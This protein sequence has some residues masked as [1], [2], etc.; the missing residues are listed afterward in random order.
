[1]HSY[2]LWD[3]AD[4]VAKLQSKPDY[5]SQDIFVVEECSELTKELMKRYRGKGDYD[6][7]IEEACDVLA[8]TIVLLKDLSVDQQTVY[9]K[10]YGKYERALTRYNENG[11]L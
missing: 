9:Q 4:E 6:R 3:K 1:M 11:E 2:T 8:A 5:P 7:I 10:V